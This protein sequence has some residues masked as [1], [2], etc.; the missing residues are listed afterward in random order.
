MFGGVIAFGIATIVF[1]LSRHFALSLVAL[2]ALGA[3]DVVSVV[4]R[5]SLVQLRTPDDMLG[6]VSAVNSLFIGT[7]NQLGE[8]ES[9]VTAAW[10]ARRRRS[11][12]VAP[13][14]L[15]SRSRGC[16]CSRNCET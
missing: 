13:R 11:S 15:R 4:V 2:A 5:L 7:S 12:W 8:F 10:W 1:G 16:G 14:R 3:S 9:G 6:R